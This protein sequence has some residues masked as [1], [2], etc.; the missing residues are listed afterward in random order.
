VLAVADAC[1]A[2]ISDRP[3]GPGSMDDEFMEALQRRGGKELDPD[4]VALFVKAHC[5]EVQ[6]EKWKVESERGRLTAV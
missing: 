5:T 1:D 3:G 4:L 2:L 6:N